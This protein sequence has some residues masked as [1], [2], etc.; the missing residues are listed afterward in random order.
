MLL[1]VSSLAR[2]QTLETLYSFQG[3]NGYGPQDLVLG[4]DGDFYGTT[5]EGGN[6]F[7]R[8]DGSLVGGA[9]TAFRISPEGTLTTLLKFTGTNGD[10]PA[11]F[12]QGSDG[13]FYGTTLFGGDLTG[14]QGLG[15]GTMF[16]MTPTG[17]LTTLIEFKTS[18]G[19]EPGN[20]RT[21]AQGSDGNFSGT[22][23]G[24]LISDYGPIRAGTVF[25]MTPQG[26]L[27]NLARFNSGNGSYPNGALVQGSDGNFY[28]TTLTGGDLSQSWGPPGQFYSIVP[29][30]GTVF[31]VTPD[32]TLT[33]LAKFEGYNGAYPRA[34]LIQAR[35][36][37]FYG[38][39]T[40]G[41]AFDG[42][43]VF[44]ITPDGVLTTLFSFDYAPNPPLFAY[45]FFGPKARLVQTR[46]GN[47]YGTVGWGGDLSLNNGNGYGMVFGMTL[48]GTIIT[49]VNFGQSTGTS[50]NTGISP[51]ALVEG[52]DGNLYG[53]T[54]F[55]G[56][57]SGTVFRLVMPSPPNLTIVPDGDQLVLSWPTNTAGFALQS[58]PELGPEAVWSDSLD[59]PDVFGDQYVFKT[60]LSAPAHFY[61][62]KK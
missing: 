51:N 47:L 53:T 52:G 42:G 36:G 46:D 30:F 56:N 48:D 20:I 34:G 13:S 45:P 19:W 14:Y 54:Y 26:T 10:M 28:G 23:Q 57:G 35:D 50:S 7:Y 25:R 18:N 22:T 59:S 41:G 60:A 5:S 33:T 9:G 32:G 2:A 3:S 16:K 27:T 8:P 21:L 17:T 38:T 24:N 31:R 37:N 11:G 12:V 49:R 44:K 61:R 40:G 29:G 6:L 39:T 43:T 58:S 55:G 62:L 4:A 15:Y 1:S